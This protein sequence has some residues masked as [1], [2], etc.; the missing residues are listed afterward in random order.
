MINIQDLITQ[1]YPKFATYPAILRQPLLAILRRLIREPEINHF[2]QQTAPIQ[3]L[4]FIDK[5][6]EHFQFNYLVSQRERENIPTQGRVLILANHPLGSLDGLALLKL[7]GEVRQDVKIIAN[8]VLMQFSPLHT[9]LLP[10]DNLTRSY[11][12]SGGRGLPCQRDRHQRWALASW[13]C[14]FCAQNQYAHFTCLYWRQKFMVF[15][16]FFLFTPTAW[17][18][19]PC[20]RNV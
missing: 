2:L 11:I 10:I 1:K 7:V 15:L 3:G 13:I 12:I 19:T 16:L 20:T 14:P 17:V 18:I 4:E 8:D 9:H 6:L 5:V